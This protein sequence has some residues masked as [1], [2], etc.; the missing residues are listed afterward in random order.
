MKT[1]NLKSLTEIFEHYKK[2]VPGVKCLKFWNTEIKCSDLESLNILL[3]NIYKKE[4]RI[5]ISNFNDFYIGYTIPQIGKEFD[6]LR[7]TDKSI[8]NIEL[9]RQITQ[10][11][12]HQLIKNKYYLKFFNKNLFFYTYAAKERKL[13]KLNEENELLEVDL[14]ELIDIIKS[15][16]DEIMINQNIDEHFKPSNYLISPFSKTEKFLNNEYFLTKEQEEIEQDILTHIK[17][18][19]KT[20]L[21]TGGAGSGKT[22]LAYHLA[23]NFI[24]N[25][26]KVAIIHMG[27]LNPGHEKL[28]EDFSWNIQPIKFWSSIFKGESPEIIIIDE[29]QRANN[30]KQFDDIINKIKEKQIILIM[31]GDKNQTFRK[32]EGW[33]IE[34][35]NINKYKLND[36]IRINKALAS[37]ITVLLDLK[38]KHHIETSS[39]NINVVYFEN[40]EDAKQYI[41]NKKNYTYIS[42]TPNTGNYG[43]R[44]EMH[45]LNFLKSNT[46]HQVIGQEF[47]NVITVLDKN[48]Y[49]DENER[50]WANKVTYNP[51]S[52]RK[53]FFQQ[54]TRAINK[55]EIVVI[56]N[57]EL[58]RKIVSI[59]E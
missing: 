3:Q 45:R 29:V 32:E 44:C 24:A 6:L 16:T 42:Y 9:K 54:I 8:L 35:A 12:Q 40:L 57:I 14:Q 22:L 21:I 53:M 17:N 31:S 56:E 52:L 48:F 11:I 46:A 1:A 10:K 49:Y 37:F 33:A 30:K 5:K 26:K 39:K 43:N 34:W 55:L 23:K 58:Y 4:P 7:F 15:Q 50:L 41:L 13:F 2:E 51:Y 20:F 25:N 27:N 19:E 28:K 59:F 18:N 38:R 36:K 47:E